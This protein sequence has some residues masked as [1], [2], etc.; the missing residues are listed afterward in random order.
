MAIASTLSSPRAAADDRPAVGWRLSRTSKQLTVLVHILTSVGLFGM[1][2]VSVAL[3]TIVSATSS[4]P[5]IPRAVL[6]ILDT[7]DLVLLPPI[8]LGALVS[9]VVLSIGTHWGL[10]NHVWIV[11]KLVL[12]I[13]VIL[14]G[15]TVIR[16][17]WTDHTPGL[18]DRW[19]RR[20]GISAPHLADEA[21][22]TWRFWEARPPL[23]C[24]S[25]GA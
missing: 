2:I 20:G 7:V 22:S 9:G 16:S 17:A 6:Q 15:A 3:A 5:A 11:T 10:F 23:P 24:S 21:P 1:T 25:P 12:T 8:A 18:R 14:T 19:R 4:D 13:A